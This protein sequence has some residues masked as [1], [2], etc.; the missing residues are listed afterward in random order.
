MPQI[1]LNLVNDI[2][3]RIENQQTPSRINVKKT[4]IRHILNKLL[5]PKDKNKILKA[6]GKMAYYM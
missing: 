4:M 2:N 5:E 3:L 6:K 1:S